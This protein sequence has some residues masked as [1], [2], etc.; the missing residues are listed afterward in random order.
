M[1]SVV[2]EDLQHFLLLIK[3]CFEVRA[4]GLVPESLLPLEHGFVLNYT[5]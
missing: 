1:F 2:T 3:L 4:R 5:V